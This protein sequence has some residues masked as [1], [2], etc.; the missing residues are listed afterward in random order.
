MPVT[1]Q[2]SPLQRGAQHR[3]ADVVLDVE[4]RAEF[5]GLRRLQP[6]IVDA[7]AAI[8]VHMPLEHL[9]VVNGMREHH[10]ASGREHDV[11]IER[12][13]EGFPQLQRMIVK[14][15]AFIE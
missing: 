8:R 2:F 4:R 9:Y 1:S 3:I 13:R 14:R 7:V 11:V 10:D 15:G 12:L 5:L 6:F